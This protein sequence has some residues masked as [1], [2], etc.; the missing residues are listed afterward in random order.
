MG[1]PPS[2][3][4]N[5][6]FHTFAKHARYADNVGLAAKEMHLYWQAGVPKDERHKKKSTWSFISKDLPSFSDPNPTFFGFNP[7][8]QKGIQCRFG[9]RVRCSNLYI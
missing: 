2:L 8:E 1:P 4:T 5:L 9:E 7:P 3:D 6:K